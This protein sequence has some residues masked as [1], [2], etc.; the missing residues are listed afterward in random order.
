[1]LVS[2]KY[3]FIYI[4]SGKTAGTS[5][6]VYLQKACFQTLGPIKEPSEEIVNDDGIVGMRAANAKTEARQFYNHMTAADIQR[7]IPELFEKY[8]KI[9]NVRNPFDI[10]VSRYW[11]VLDAQKR[12]EMQHANLEKIK[13]DFAEF[14]WSRPNFNPLVQS[15]SIDGKNVIDFFI[16][17]EQL[18]K[19]I[20][21]L[22][23]KLGIRENI[24][25][26]KLKTA[27]RRI[28]EHYSLY[29]SAE[30]IS[31]FTSKWSFL[32]HNLGYD[33]EDRS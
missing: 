20:E 8:L 10:L 19:D 3:K 26:P 17:Y 22:T 25:I 6:E 18:E 5:T 14:C 13:G 33:F 29:Y 23:K 1:M 30:L 31:H 11:H 15:I 4:K 2:H 28:G 32:L 7:E 16:R 9:C 21:T 24:E 12:D 27:H